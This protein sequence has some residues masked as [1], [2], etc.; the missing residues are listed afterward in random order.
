MFG[1]NIKYLLGLE[2]RKQQGAPD[3]VPFY[4]S[5]IFLNSCSCFYF[6]NQK[7]IPTFL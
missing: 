2:H 5:L 4:T 6:I 1:G 7:E 3:V